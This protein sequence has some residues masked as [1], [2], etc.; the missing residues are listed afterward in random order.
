LLKEP[1]RKKTYIFLVYV[2][3]VLVTFIAYERLRHNDFV[4]YDDELYVT[5][6]PHVCGGITRESIIWVFTTPH[7]DASYWLPLTWLSH[8]LDCQLFGLRAPGHHLTSL[9]FHTVNALLL[10]WILKSTTGAV[11]RSVFVAA[12][13]ALHPLRVESVAW[14]AER[15]DVLSGFFWMLT[16]AAYILYASRPGIKRYLPVVLTFCLGLM[17]KP[18]VVTLP[19]V[20]LLLDYWP[21]GRFQWKTKGQ[22]EDLSQ[23]E[24]AKVTCRRQP[25]WWLLVE[26]IP[27]F[28]LAGASSLLTYIVVQNLG[29]HV[30]YLSLKLRIGNALVSYVGY[31]VKTFYPVHLAVFYPYRPDVGPLWQ[32][33][34]CF[35]IL[36]VGSAAVIYFGR[37]RRYLMVGWLWYLGTLVPVIGLVQVGSQAMADRYSYLSTIGLLIMICWGAAELAKRMRYREIVLAAVMVSAALALAVG[38]WLQVGYWQNSITLFE[39]AVAVTKDNYLAHNNLG[40]EL[41]RQGKVNKAIEHYAE[42]VRIWPAGK[43]ALTNL[44]RLL[45][46]KG[47]VDEVIGYYREY[48]QEEPKDH[49]I[50]KQ[51]AD[52]LV[53]Q[54]ESI[55]HGGFGPRYLTRGKLDEAVKHYRQALRL[56]RDYFEAHHRLAVVLQKQGKLEAAIRHYREAL[57]LNPEDRKVRQA[58]EAALSEQNKLRKQETQ[59]EKD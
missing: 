41:S 27:L 48:L 11:W 49:Q 8:M 1:S 36:V 38:T 57:K 13:F 25:L 55:S 51:L 31:I 7:G 59:G 5:K 46:R 19:F 45:T 24:S 15:K 18:M 34:V 12:V 21:L 30:G 37:R 3:L 10:F 35:T 32:L 47:R 6:N 23:L 56:K 20:L 33:I 40:V 42:A 14:V 26:K 9:L 44:A 17:A 43:V 28:I 54:G 52:A 53:L 39:H 2:L 50:H 16:I 58:L 29:A 4:S 22:P